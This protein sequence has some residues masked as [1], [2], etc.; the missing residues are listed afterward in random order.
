MTA[1]QPAIS[2]ADLARFIREVAEGNYSAQDWSRIAMRHYRDDKM[3]YARWKLVRY[4]LGYS[5]P[6]QEAYSSGKELL[7]AIAAELESRAATGG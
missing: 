5:V 7:I 4:V 2:R 6:G 1:R 3:D